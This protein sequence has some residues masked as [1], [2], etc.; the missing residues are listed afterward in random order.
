MAAISKAKHYQLADDIRSFLPKIVSAD[1]GGARLQCDLAQLELVFEKYLI[2]LAQLHDLI[3]A[4]DTVQHKI[5]VQL[6][7]QQLSNSR[8]KNSNRVSAG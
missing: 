5:K 1:E 6:R 8:Q 2:S 4:Y 7:K 3:K